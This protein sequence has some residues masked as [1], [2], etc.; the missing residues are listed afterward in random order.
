[1]ARRDDIV[2]RPKGSSW[3]TS[4]N[5]PDALRRQLYQQMLRDELG[6]DPDYRPTEAK[7]PSL[8]ASPIVIGILAFLTFVAVLGGLL[9][10]DGV[11]DN[12]FVWPTQAKPS[13]DWM[14]GDR[15]SSTDAVAND[16]APLESLVEDA[17]APKAEPPDEVTTP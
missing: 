3:R 13:A 14:L 10:R 9:W 11:F 12:A 17:P 6:R 2:E 4:A 16:T 15:Q 8:L 1:M 7:E 5:A